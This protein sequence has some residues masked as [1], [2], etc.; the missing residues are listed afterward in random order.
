M[1][2]LFLSFFLIPLVINSGQNLDSLYN[3]LLEIKGFAN[4]LPV[5]QH[6]ITAAGEHVKCLTSLVNDLRQNINQ[7][8]YE[9][10]IVIQSILDRPVTDTSFVTL[11]GKFRI[12]YNKTGSNAPAYDLNLLAKAADSSYNYEVNILGY[13]PPPSDSGDGGDDRYDI[14]IQ[15][16]GDNGNYGYTTSER[17]ITAN[18]F[19]SFMVIDNAFAGNNFYTNGIDAA[20]V[21]VAHEFHHGIQFGNYIYRSS[22]TFYNELTSTS[23]EHFV[24]GSIHDYYQYLPLY[25]SY[26]QRTFSQNDGYNLAIWNIFLGNHLGMDVIKRSWE[27]MPTERALKA[28]A[29]AIQEAH[30]TLKIEL[31][32]FGQWTYFT[33]IRS[34][35]GNYFK[36]AANYPLIT[37]ARVLN[38]SQS[39]VTLLTNPVSNSFIVFTAQ[40]SSS[41]DSLVA[42]ITNSDINNGINK[43]DST[44][45]IKYWLSHSKFSGYRSVIGN[46]FSKIETSNS[47]LISE[48]DIYNDSLVNKGQVS[49]G[50]LAYVFPQPFKY[51]FN[52]Y[53]YFPAAATSA[54]PINLYVYSID[55]KLIYSGRITVV[56][57]GKTGKWNVLDNNNRKLATGVYLYLTDS[58]GIIK[59]GKFVV[60]NE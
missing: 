8:S 34:V 37:P 44:L 39:P 59:K 58:G 10:K 25:F 48:S 1:T 33:G 54:G 35:P 17:Y 56:E 27:L 26:T 18:T 3:K 7:Y 11:S 12:H 22:D 14:Y 53:L 32:V 43:P 15:N 38:I 42:I 21:T 55:M 57:S 2:K 31:N 20:R 28:I 29:D 9:K 4:T 40:G 50:E 13:P 19:T 60:F 24:F 52:N 36:E 51:S 30:S 5:K 49:F 46:Y 16:Q 47:L 41:T 45:T 6:N 23:M